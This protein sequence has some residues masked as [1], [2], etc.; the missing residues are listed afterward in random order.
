MIDELIKELKAAGLH[1]WVANDTVEKQYQAY[2]IQDGK[3][4]I[5]TETIRQ[6]DE[7][8]TSMHVFV[9]H[10]GKLGNAAIGRLSRNV[11]IGQQVRDAATNALSVSNP[12]WELPDAPK[13]IPSVQTCDTAI[14]SNP[15]QC[16]QQIIDAVRISSS[17]QQGV[18]FNNAEVFV[19]HKKIRTLTSKGFD[20]MMDKS[21]LYMEVA[22]SRHEQDGR[23]DELLRCGHAT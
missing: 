12:L 7:H 4:G 15:D 1:G 3:G 8:Y 18:I 14:S 13:S 17:R 16:M 10:D 19:T 5:E 2:L 21:A 11:P 22:F 20:G 9:E 23:A 6:V